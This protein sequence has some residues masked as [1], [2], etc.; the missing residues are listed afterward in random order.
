[1]GMAEAKANG[2]V[3]RSPEHEIA[4]KKVQTPGRQIMFEKAMLRGLVAVAL[5][6]KTIV[7]AL[8]L[9]VSAV[10]R[11]DIVLTET[12]PGE[13]SITVPVGQ[14]WFDVEVQCWGAGGYGW[15]SPGASGCWG[16]G[17]GGYSQIT[18]PSLS[19]GTY[20][21]QVGQSPGIYTA[22]G[23]STTVVAADTLFPYS[24]TL[25]KGA[26]MAW[27]S[28]GASANWTGPGVNT[29]QYG[30]GGVDRNG[31]YAPGGNG[32]VAVL[33]GGG[34]AAQQAPVVVVV[35][36]L[37]PQVVLVVR[38][39]VVRA[40]REVAGMAPLGQTLVVVVVREQLLDHL[41]ATAKSSSP[42]TAR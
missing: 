36:V 30:V 16:G 27:A 24:G 9:S 14:Q 10:A 38:V 33:G 2:V 12:T 11:A 3:G 25:V 17:G 31:V 6:A 34:G 40:V 4:N 26:T 19:A 7:L 21:Y 39:V 23:N 22:P 32:V 20:G 41:A 35:M 15:G 1:M 18:L 8:L 42:I 28:G 13:G 29:G 37:V 5:R